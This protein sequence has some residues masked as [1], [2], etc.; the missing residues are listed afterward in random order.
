MSERSSRWLRQPN[1]VVEI[2]A[3]ERKVVPLEWFAGF[4][5]LRSNGENIVVEVN[6]DNIKQSQFYISLSAA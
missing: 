5:L 4:Y 2:D 3:A 6:R 1:C